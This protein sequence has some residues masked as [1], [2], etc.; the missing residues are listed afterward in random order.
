ML[1]K[2]HLAGSVLIESIDVFKEPSC[3]KDDYFQP[4]HH[5]YQCGEVGGPRT[6]PVHS[7]VFYDYKPLMNNC[8]LLMDESHL[9]KI[10]KRKKSV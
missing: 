3:S 8:P 6:N 4:S 10:V 1:I 7:E 9:V 5:L 2:E